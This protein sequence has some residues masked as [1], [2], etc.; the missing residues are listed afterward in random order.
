[1]SYN[2]KVPVTSKPAKLPKH[3]TVQNVLF[4]MKTCW[5]QEQLRPCLVKDGISSLK[6]AAKNDR[7]F[8][9]K[10]LESGYVFY[11]I[12][13][14]KKNLTRCLYKVNENM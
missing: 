7:R 11:I 6:R 12:K 2:I 9:V 14:A 3:M 5:S 1:M 8:L 13:H 10:R 4:D